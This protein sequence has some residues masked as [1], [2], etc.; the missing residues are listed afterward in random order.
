MTNI[1]CIYF[2]SND[3]CKNEKVNEQRNCISKYLFSLKKCTLLLKPQAKCE[4]MKSYKKPEP[5]PSPPK[6][7]YY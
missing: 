7:D 4:Y 1:N 5:S 6:K 2:C 3:K